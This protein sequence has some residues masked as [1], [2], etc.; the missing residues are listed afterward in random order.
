MVVQT[1]PYSERHLINQRLHDLLLGGIVVLSTNEK[2]L[3]GHSK[4]SFGWSTQKP[5]DLDALLNF[6]MASTSPFVS[7]TRCKLR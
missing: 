7:T 2:M 1:S 5:R 3:S 6:A 4:P